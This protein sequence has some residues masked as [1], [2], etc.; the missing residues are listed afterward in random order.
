MNEWYPIPTQYVRANQSD[1]IRNLRQY[2]KNPIGAK[3]SLLTPRDAF[4]TTGDP[5]ETRLSES[6]ND[7]H[8]SLGVAQTSVFVSCST[9]IRVCVLYCKL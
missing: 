1:V 6:E 5:A 7:L 2:L 3:L 4:E 9:N 8:W